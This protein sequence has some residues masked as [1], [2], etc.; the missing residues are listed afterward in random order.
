MHEMVFDISFF[1]HSPNESNK[2]TSKKVE[3][4]LYPPA[5][6]PVRAGKGV[7]TGITAFKAYRF[8]DNNSF[9]ISLFDLSYNRE[10]Y[11]LRF[12]EI[13]GKN[14]KAKIDLSEFSKVYLSDMN[15]NV[16]KELTTK[17]GVIEL[18][19]SSYEIV[20]LLMR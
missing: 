5:V 8:I 9:V 18:D 13:N 2:E 10:F 15:E 3:V 14:A 19:V 16:G 11:L 6:H 7:N 20:T 4:F 1:T 12:Y 17:D